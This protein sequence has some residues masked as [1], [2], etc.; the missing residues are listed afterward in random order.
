MTATVRTCPDCHRPM[1]QKHLETCAGPIQRIA[2]APAREPE[3][4]CG[5]GMFHRPDCQL[6]TGRPRGDAA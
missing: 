6:V 1:W 5:P 2:P 3:C 4:G